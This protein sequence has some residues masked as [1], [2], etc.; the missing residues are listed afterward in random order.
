MNTIAS[1]VAIPTLAEYYY[2][3]HQMED[4]VVWKEILLNYCFIIDSYFWGLRKLNNPTAH[5]F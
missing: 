1:N 5:K 2:K 4:S 3:K